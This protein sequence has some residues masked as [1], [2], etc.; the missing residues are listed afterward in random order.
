M[1]TATTIEDYLYDNTEDSSSPRT[2]IHA[3]EFIPKLHAFCGQ[4]D[5]QQQP[6]E[7]TLD[8]LKSTVGALTRCHVLQAV[9]LTISASSSTTIK[10]IHT[11]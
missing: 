7:A 8:Y 9:L 2:F 11:F 1:T 3:K 10:M 4:D 6:D 5:G